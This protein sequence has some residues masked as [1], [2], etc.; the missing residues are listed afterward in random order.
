ME[1]KASIRPAYQQIKQGEPVEFRCQA[2]GNPT[3]QLDWIRIGGQMN[4]E[5]TFENGVWRIPAV[6]KADEAEYK[7]IARNDIGMN[8]QTTILYV[9]DNPNGPAPTGRDVPP[10]ITPNEWNGSAGDIVRMVCTR[11]NAHESVTWQRSGGLALPSSATQQDGIL[12]IANPG[13]TDSG[14]S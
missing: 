14:K 11:S 9:H 10:I 3:P 7:C 5:A 1:P 6:T 12:T 13:I 8:E 4:P 2:T